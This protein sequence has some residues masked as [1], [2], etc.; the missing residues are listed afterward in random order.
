MTQ[1]E[2]KGKSIL[3]VDDDRDLAEGIAMYLEREGYQVTTVTEAISCYVAFH[4]ASY[5]LTLIDPSLSD[6]DGLV[7]VRYLRINTRTAVMLF[8]ARA[9]IDDRRKAF[10]AGA[11]VFIPKP[12]AFGKRARA[13][14]DLLDSMA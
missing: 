10:G 6:Q 12:V 3:I 5:D 8:S 2:R 9:T 14:A 7:L 13:I 1:T 4:G 11:H